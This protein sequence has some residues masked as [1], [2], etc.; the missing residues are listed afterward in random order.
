MLNITTGLTIWCSEAI[1]LATVLFFAWRHDRQTPAYLMWSLG[2]TVSAVGFALVAARGFI[3]DFLS[4]EVGNGI[5]LLGESAWIA[6]FCW[7]DNRRL[8]WRALFPPAIWFAGVELPWI[9]ESFVNRVIL[10]DLAG[11]VGATLLAAA[12]R[13][14]EGRREGVRGLLGFVFMALACLCFVS[15]MSMTLL[16]L[17]LEEAQSYRSYSALGSALLITTAIALTGKLMMERSERR[18]R[19]ISVTDTLTGVLNRRG[20]QDYF[21]LVAGKTT[22]DS[23]KIATLLFDL[24]HFK[25]INDRYGHQT[26]DIVLAEF[27]RIGRQ[28]VPRNGAFGRMGGEEFTA[29]ILVDDQAEAEAIAETIRLDFCRVPLLAGRSLVPATVSIGLAIMPCENANWDRLVSAADRALYA[30]K[31]GGR[32]CT[33]VFSEAEAAMATDTPPD[34]NGGELV[35]T[36]DDQIHALRRLGTLAR[37]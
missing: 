3:P 14:A 28:F 12:V 20:L 9:H 31:R 25:A 13:P 11:A 16:Q 5:A 15:A 24:D 32:N 7:M 6:G 35:P 10:Y 21:E 33:I 34:S 26:G 18:W 30:A 29:F 19:A 17:N 2:F 36:L 27:A 23:Q 8:D 1:T 4:I 22:K 37:M